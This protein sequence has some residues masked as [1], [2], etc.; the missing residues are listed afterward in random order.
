[1]IKNNRKK[2]MIPQDKPKISTKKTLART[3]A[4]DLMPAVPHNAAK[5]VS[6]KLH[7]KSLEETTAV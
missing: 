5:S 2:S 1:M 4:T 3:E 7:S 6:L